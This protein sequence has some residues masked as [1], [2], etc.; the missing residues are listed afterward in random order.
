M[1]SMITVGVSL[2]IGVLPDLMEPT[3]LPLKVHKVVR[4]PALFGMLNP[5]SGF[6]VDAGPTP[7]H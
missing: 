4:A 1:L 7:F 5:P 2:V 3:S 6:D